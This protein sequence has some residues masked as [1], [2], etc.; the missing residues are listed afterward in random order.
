MKRE[1]LE[2]QLKEAFRNGTEST[3]EMLFEALLELAS[4][5]SLEE[6]HASAVRS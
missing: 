3:K 2:N 6:I 1:E 5:G 4:T